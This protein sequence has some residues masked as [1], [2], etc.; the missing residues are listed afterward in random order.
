MIIRRFSVLDAMILVAATAVGFAGIRGCSPEYYTWPY[1]PIPPLPWLN[2]SAVTLAH[3]AFYVSPLPAAWTFTALVPRLRSPRPSMPRLMRQPGAVASSAA[4]M[5]ILMGAIHYLVDLRNTASWHD[6][7]I[8]LTVF[9]LGC[10]V[11]SAW[12]ILALGRH[13]RAEPSW[14]DRLGRVLG[15]YRIVMVPIMILRTFGQS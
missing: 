5:L 8:E 1:T 4:T 6:T 14:I 10:G 11:A 7:P 2:R 12:L 15:V 13:W 3:W 9:S